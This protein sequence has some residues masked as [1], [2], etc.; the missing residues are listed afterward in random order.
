MKKY[1][2]ILLSLS[3]IFAFA[4]CGSNQ[5]DMTQPVFETDNIMGVTVYSMPDFEEGIPVPDEDMDT[6]IHWI[7]SFR[8]D[9]K[10]GK[11][12]DKLDP[13]TGIRSFAIEYLD[14]TIVESDA[15]TITIDGTIYYMKSESR[16]VCIEELFAEKRTEA[17]NE[18]L[19]YL[20]E[21]YGLAFK[22]WGPEGQDLYAYRVYP[23]HADW[24]CH[25]L[26]PANTD[27]VEQ[28]QK[29]LSWEVVGNELMIC[30]IGREWQETLTIDIFRETATS[31][32]TGRVYQIYEMDPPLE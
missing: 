20:S 26:M 21:K 9:K 10:A 23:D 31:V 28:Y 5:I 11:E 17:D 1:I 16:P 25:I 13:G 19:Q 12:G 15:N 27:D 30:S 6:V 22:L 18:V 4:A 3:C 14:G 8:L 32:T 24:E 7:S 29:N 2:A